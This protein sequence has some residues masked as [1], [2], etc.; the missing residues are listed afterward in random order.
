MKKLTLALSALIALSASAIDIPKAIYVKKGDEFTKF[1][2]GVADDL[3]FSDNGRKLS[4]TGYKEVIDLD[5][6]DYI[7]FSAPIDRT[8][9]TPAAQKEKLLQIGR[10]AIG[11]VKPADQAELLNV[12][13]VLFIG[14]HDGADY[15]GPLTNGS[16]PDDYI[17][18]KSAAKKIATGLR[19]LAK[20][21][22][23]GIRATRSGS[24]DLYKLDDY[25]GVFTF[26]P[27]KYVWEKTSDAGYL[28]L[29][30]KAKDG[31]DCSVRLEATNN[32]A[33]KWT[34]PDV[35]IEMPTEA[36]TTI[37]RNGK[38]LA[39]SVI[40]TTMVQDKSIEMTVDFEANGYEVVNNFSVVNDKINDSVSV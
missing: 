14:Y 18:V 15:H 1:N 26:N 6:I 36:T 4:V 32:S 20:G 38:A 3:K 13:E 10:E 28:E 2:F 35:E 16:F 19:M 11:M 27:D 17:K 25:Y 37:Y 40:K 34:T 9:L 23:T 31:V 33:V 30:F 8:A 24:I 5:A 7:S 29:R 21:N 39:S 22:P 12:I